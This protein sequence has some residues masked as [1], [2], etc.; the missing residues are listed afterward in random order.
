MTTT[1]RHDRAALYATDRSATA[2]AISDVVERLREM[3]RKADSVIRRWSFGSLAANLLPPPFDTVMV[4]AAF[5]RMGERIGAAYE[6]KLTR[7]ELKA[8]SRALLAGTSGV[9]LASKIGTDLFKFVP[10]VN[11]WVALLI[12][13]PIVGA[14]GYSVGQGFKSYYQLRIIEGAE[15]TPAQLQEVT[16]IA[17]KALKVRL[18]KPK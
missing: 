11:I 18:G 6:M 12:Q 1:T 4:A 13:P 5:A 16:A 9:V 8:V 15:L 10:G 7:R 14:I 3:D 17:A 2:D